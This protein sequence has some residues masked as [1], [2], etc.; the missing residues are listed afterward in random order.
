MGE[1]VN[2]RTARK[3]RDRKAREEK[4]DEN[5]ARFGRSK[6]ERR[7]TAAE[8]EHAA[9]RLDASR[10]DHAAIGQNRPI[11]ENVVDP[12]SVERA[13]CEEPAS[14]FSQRALEPK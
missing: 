4:A 9:A 11:A 6:A 5:R 14:A 8:R 13:G 1:V 10:L 2:L 12:K 7:V 3:Q